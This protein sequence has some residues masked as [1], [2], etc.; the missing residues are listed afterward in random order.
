MHFWIFFYAAKAIYISSFFKNF[1]D[2]VTSVTSTQRKPCHPYLQQHSSTELNCIEFNSV[3][4]NS[5]KKKKLFYTKGKLNVITHTIQISSNNLWKDPG[6]IWLF[7]LVLW[8]VFFFCFKLI[9]WINDPTRTQIP[10]YSVLLTNFT[11]PKP[12]I[13]S[14]NVINI[15]NCYFIYRSNNLLWKA[16]SFPS[17]FSEPLD[18]FQRSI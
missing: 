9:N 10:E 5:I 3:Q 14:A 11:E 17:V 6:G 15:K 7:C 8:F 12:K 1:Y 4:F 13:H 16:N 2:W 18:D